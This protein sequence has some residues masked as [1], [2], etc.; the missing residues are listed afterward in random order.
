M[1]CLI[2]RERMCELALVIHVYQD[3]FKL[4]LCINDNLMELH[5]WSL[6][7]NRTESQIIL[8]VFWDFVSN[9]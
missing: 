8:S 5:G 2:A 6:A 1:V 7:K 9:N 4:L 3:N